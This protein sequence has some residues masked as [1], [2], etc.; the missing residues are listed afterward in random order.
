[1]RLPNIPLG[2]FFGG[3]VPK[4]QSRTPIPAK[5]LGHFR[6]SML[7]SISLRNKIKTS[8]NLET[9]KNNS[10]PQHLVIEILGKNV[11]GNYHNF[12][13]KL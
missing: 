4:I 12:Q 6:G 2:R 3:V 1:L 5:P 11:P 9:T 10:A 13:T 7:L 8:P